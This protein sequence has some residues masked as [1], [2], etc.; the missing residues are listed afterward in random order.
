VCDVLLTAGVSWTECFVCMK[1]VCVTDSML[2]A[3]CG[4]HHPLLFVV[5]SLCDAGTTC[6]RNAIG[7]LMLFIVC[8]L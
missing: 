6:G 3:F 7:L 1:H 5:I 8:R 2:R 4:L